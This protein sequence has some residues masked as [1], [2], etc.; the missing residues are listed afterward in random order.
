MSKKVT[1]KELSNKANT[2]KHYKM[3]YETLWGKVVLWL[4]LIGMVGGVILSFV[5]ALISGQA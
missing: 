4:L 3:P 2:E 5:V 1:K